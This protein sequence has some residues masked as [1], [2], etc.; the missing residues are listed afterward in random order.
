V[1]AGKTRLEII[2]LPR[3]RHQVIRW[4]NSEYISTLREDM[5]TIMQICAP[6]LYHR[7]DHNIAT[8]YSAIHTY[9]LSRLTQT[10]FPSPPLFDR[11]FLAF[12]ELCELDRIGSKPH[13]SHPLS[14]SILFV[15]CPDQMSLWS[16]EGHQS[17]GIA[18]LHPTSLRL[19]PVSSQGESC[20]SKLP[21]PNTISSQPTIAPCELRS[22]PSFP[23]IM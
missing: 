15:K 20:T 14:L 1:G 12:V 22:Y 9:Q 10:A 21:T 2:H 8:A 23:I 18:S 4:D 3:N 6:V 19:N 13:L 5:Q 17:N 7:P 16:R 11:S